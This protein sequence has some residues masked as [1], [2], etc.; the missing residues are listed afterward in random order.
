MRLN[1]PMRCQVV[2]PESVGHLLNLF[3]EIGVV[4][5]GAVEFIRYHQDHR[6]LCACTLLVN[7]GG[8][9]TLK[10]PGSRVFVPKSYLFFLRRDLDHEAH[11]CATCKRTPFRLRF[12]DTERYFL[13][14][15][16]TFVILRYKL[17]TVL[18]RHGQA[19]EKY[20]G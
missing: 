14:F 18:V 13:F 16:R 5:S 17:C 9:A 10:F 2:P 12:N 7:H 20:E 3:I 15:S 4:L 8:R 1:Q 6:V 11:D 19:E